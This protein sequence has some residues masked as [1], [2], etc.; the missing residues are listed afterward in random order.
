M[1]KWL[2]MTLIV[3]NFVGWWMPILEMVQPRSSRIFEAT[4]D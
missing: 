2:I 1:P 3:F 4:L